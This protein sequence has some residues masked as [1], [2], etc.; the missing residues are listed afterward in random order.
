MVLYESVMETT[1]SHIVSLMKKF[2]FSTKSISEE[3]DYIVSV[4]AF[5]TT[6]HVM[7]TVFKNF[8]HGR[9]CLS[10]EN[11]K[12]LVDVRCASPLDRVFEDA[13]SSYEMSFKD[14]FE[15]GIEANL[16][17]RRTKI[18]IEKSVEIDDPCL[19]YRFTI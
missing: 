10:V 8:F 3:E 13:I 11:G 18:S 1:K 2:D 12:L 4:E 9:G 14:A 6:P 5:N 16:I 15:A 19:I 7:A 17:P